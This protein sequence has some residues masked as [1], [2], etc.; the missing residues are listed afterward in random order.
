M[1]PPATVT[2]LE[3]GKMVQATCTAGDAG[4]CTTWELLNLGI[5][6][7]TIVVHASNALDAMLMVQILGPTGC[8]GMGPDVEKTVTVTALS[9]SS[10][11]TS[12]GGTA[13]M[14]LCCT[15]SNDFPDLCLTGAC[16]CAPQNSKMIQVCNCPQGKCYKPNV[17]CM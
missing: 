15:S 7:H 4:A 12:T 10:L 2:F 6:A 14:Q 13:G 5:G 1:Q 3:S 11:C 8:C 17:G 9:P 16:G